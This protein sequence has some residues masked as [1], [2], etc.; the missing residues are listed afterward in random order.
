MKL[1]EITL[2]NF[3]C[4]ERC[5]LPL[6]PG[7]TVLVGNNG[8]G[9]SAVLDGIAYALG[10]ILSRLPRIGGK[11]LRSEDIHL[12]FRGIQAPFVRIESTS[13]TDV[14]WARTLKRDATKQTADDVPD[15]VGDKALFEYLDPLIH[16]INEGGK[17]TLP[18]FAY[19]GTSRAVLDVPERRRNFDRKVGRFDALKGALESS[20]RFKETFL[21]LYNVQADEMDDAACL[22]PRLIKLN[23]LITQESGFNAS[24]LNDQQRQ[25]YGRFKT[26]DSI[27]RA[28]E[29]AVPLYKNPRIKANPL[30]MVMSEHTGQDGRR[31]LSLQMLSD[32]YRTMIALVMDFARRLAQANPHLDDPLAAE[33]ILMVD[34]I[35]LHLHPI[36]QQ[37][38]IPSLRQSFPNTQ[39]IVSTHSP[40]VLSTVPTERIYIVDPKGVRRCE[41]PTYGARSS[42]LISEVL[43]LPNLRPPENEISSKISALFRA[44][45]EADVDGAK[46]L[47]A[48]LE[49]WAKG[50]PEPDLVR[51]D[52]LIRRLEHLAK[53]A[54]QSV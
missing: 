26:R 49:K 31:E 48:E 11:N 42:D 4:F 41:A 36:W 34:E 29:L 16:N 6:L 10:R 53:R 2:T 46:V 50:F 28:I 9:K 35:D 51:A 33:A 15:A 22:M 12:N 20:G 40:Q 37:K 27:R 38:V 5:S 30:R 8:A 45:D 32:G 7:L 24:L 18:V 44:L 54:V 23:E 47:R 19:Y 25:A 17:A 43:G 3:R 39:M 52:I 1:R 14:R 13:T 21:W